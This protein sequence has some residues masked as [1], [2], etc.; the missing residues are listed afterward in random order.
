[1]THRQKIAA[2]IKNHMSDCWQLYLMLI[3]VLA[4]YIIF[5]YGPM[6]G[7]QIAFKKFSFSLGIHGS[8]YVGLQYFQEFFESIYFPRLMRNT[9]LLSL[10][11]LLIGFPAP[12]LLALL[13]NE[14][15]KSRFLTVAQTSTYLPHFISLVV[16][17]SLVKSFVASNGLITTFLTYFGLEAHNYILDEKAYRTIYVV[18]DIW[19]T[20]GWGSIIYFAALSSIDPSLYEV[21][22]LDGAGRIRQ[23]LSVTLPGLMPTIIVMLI[24]RIGHL[25]DLGFEKTLLLYNPSTYET[26]DIISSY[27]YRKGLEEMNYSYSTAV[28]FFNSVINFVLIISVNQL[29]KRVTNTSLF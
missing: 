22:K 19:Q 23:I 7:I 2:R 25:M 14:V 18:S 20:A 4:Y 29:S 9:I 3:P 15:R 11:S 12:I 16:V 24:L 26:S 21:A 28:D 6:Y 13:F 5:Q 1:M 27:V 10:Y 17:C 8:R